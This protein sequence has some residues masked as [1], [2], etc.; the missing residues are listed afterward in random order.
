MPPTEA[1]K[2]IAAQY[3][4]ANQVLGITI[5]LLAKF[6]VLSR[7]R[8]PRYP[9][10]LVQKVVYR[11]EGHHWHLGTVLALHSPVPESQA[12]HS[13]QYDGDFGCSAISQRIADGKA[14]PEVERLEIEMMS[15]SGG[16]RGKSRSKGGVVHST[17]APGQSQKNRNNDLRISH[18]QSR[19]QVF[20]TRDREIMLCDPGQRHA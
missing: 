7:G 18:A 2:L 13:C 19:A 3:V 6:S 4:Y 20:S 17:T 1:A 5:Q 10:A 15:G 12:Q 8:A 16:L 9:R 14:W 11:L